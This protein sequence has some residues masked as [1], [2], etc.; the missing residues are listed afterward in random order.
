[1]SIPSIHHAYHP[2]GGDSI[3]ENGSELWSPLVINEPSPGWN[4][5]V[6]EAR[7]SVAHS[8]SIGLPRDNCFSPVAKAPGKRREMRGA[9]LLPYFTL[10][11]GGGGRHGPTLEVSAGRKDIILL[12]ISC[13]ADLGLVI[14]S[15]LSS[16]KICRL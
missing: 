16:N 8:P 5:V 15:T 2:A 12:N 4:S 13:R 11:G 14:S 10:Q 6:Y 1:M 7:N 9:P 3:R